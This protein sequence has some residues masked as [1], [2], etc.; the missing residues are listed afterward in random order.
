MGAGPQEPGSDRATR[1]VIEDPF[2]SVVRRRHPDVDI[3]LLPPETDGP[4]ETPVETPVEPE[5]PVEEPDA[6]AAAADED[7]RRAWTQLVGDR[8]LQAAQAE[9]TWS[10]RWISGRAEGRVRREATLRL[11][12]ASVGLVLERLPEA[13]ELLRTDG[14][15]VVVPPDGLPRVMAGR[16]AALGR[17]ELQLVLDPDSGRL[18]MRV[19]GADH[20][21][22]EPV[23][24]ELV[25]S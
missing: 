10:A 6:V 7:V 13:A 18:L 11:D 2:W 17:T 8:A 21:V 25:G 16:D 20:V 19:R 22:G 12:G 24:R 14:W 23:A 4:A 1:A 9:P 15:H 3:V 5:A